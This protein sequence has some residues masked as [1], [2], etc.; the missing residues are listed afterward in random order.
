MKPKI[1]FFD[2]ASCEGCQL[3]VVNLEMEIP[4][5]LGLV[6]IVAFRE[7]MTEASDDYA[8]A[9]VEGSI[10]RESDIPRLKKIREH[11]KILVALGACASSA[12]LNALKNKMGMARVKTI[13]Y[14]DQA[15]LYETFP[16]RP[17]HAVVPVDYHIPGCPSTRRNLFGWCRHCCWEKKPEIPDYPVCVECKLK[18]NLCVYEL[19]Q[20]CLGPITRAGCGAWCPSNLDACEGC[21]GYISDPNKNGQADIMAKYG[22]S[23]EMI[24]KE[25]RL[26]NA[27]TEDSNEQ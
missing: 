8:I 16:A 1:A 23:A 7:A 15:G 17:I 25:F 26:F 19:G 20:K 27:Y 13:V 11:A 3:Q 2:F 14:G 6:D 9:L 4:T 22:L 5:L 21:R 12:G 10:T 18:D 24:K